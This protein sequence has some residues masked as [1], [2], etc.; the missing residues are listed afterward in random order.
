MAT[1]NPVGRRKDHRR[2]PT[3][4]SQERP[5]VPSGAAA[6]G[7]VQRSKLVRKLISA[8]SRRIALVVAP[9]GYGKSV[10]LSQWAE[11]DTREF[12]WLS[13]ADDGHDLAH[14]VSA[15]SADQ[16]RFVVVLDDAQLVDPARLRTMIEAS[17]ELVPE[18]STIALASRVEPLLPLGSFRAHRMLTEIRT[19]ELAM[20]ASQ[21]K[22]VLAGEGVELSPAELEQLVRHTEGWPAALYLAAL[23]RRD[24]PTGLT[25]AY[26]E[27]RLISAYLRDEVLQP[28]RPELR[29]LALLTSVLDEP[30]G[31][32][33]DMLVRRHDSALLLDELARVCP[34]LMPVDA[35]G[36]RYRWHG[37]MRA[38]LRGRLK[39]GAPELKQALHIRACD[40]FAATGATEQAIDHAVAAGATGRAAGLLWRN[41]IGYLGRSN[42]DRVRAWLD[43][44]DRERISG[45]ARLAL[46]ASLCSLTEADLDQAQHW[47]LAT[48]A[49]TERTGP[50][51]GRGPAVIGRV[52]AVTA[53]GCLTVME[54]LAEGGLRSEPPDSQ[55]RPLCLLLRA[56]ALHLRG[57]GAAASPMLE[58]AVVLSGDTS[59]ILTSTCLGQL[60]MLA[61]EQ[62]DWALAV[63]S[64]DRALVLLERCEL[65]DEPLSALA[66]AAA[67]LSRAQQGRVDEAK[68]A[69]R[70]GLERLASLGEFV[71]W[72]GAEARILLA[73]AS[74][75]LTDVGEAR[76]LL[77]EASR[78]ARRTPDAVIFENWFDQAWAYVD[79][80]AETHLSGP[81]SLTVA[82]L[83][84]LRFLP[85]HHSFREI[86][87]QL[88]VSANTVKTQAHAV[89]RKLDAAS[90]SEAVARA[91]ETGLLGR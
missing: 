10:L 64:T 5:C 52:N 9:C 87:S 23:A 46:I 78:L 34:L 19:H 28:M 60:A 86:A 35:A 61:I 39:H 51:R 65:Q 90:R 43:V 76:A 82:E 62:R 70:N 41:V 26:A 74:L 69:L 17:L 8:S 31:P 22:L 6:G 18:G 71:P 12:H 77:A 75:L 67:A 21:A 72:Y 11:Q 88:G 36:D 83:R 1:V 37:L 59:P 66:F 56:V 63:D 24:D 30:S 81:A 42:H 49:A 53:R 27:R 40:W 80:L 7:L 50:D 79:E 3:G 48:V 84:I 38:E 45:N 15:A 4:A 13:A 2:W 57:D 91:L 16:A 58:E 54:A 14:A 85:S 55:W 32:G 29:T 33:C 20:T 47:L 68:V 25:P 89:Y 44:L 73:H